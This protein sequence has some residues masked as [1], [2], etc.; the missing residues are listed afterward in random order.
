MRTLK[1]SG[2]IVWRRIYVCL[3]LLNSL[4]KTDQK[5]MVSHIN[6]VLKWL[7]LYLR[8]LRTG[9]AFRVAKWIGRALC[10]I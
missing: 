9:L 1:K 2:G 6:P 5:A 8:Y 7:I 4:N 3:T 10:N